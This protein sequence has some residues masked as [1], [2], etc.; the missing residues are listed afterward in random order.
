[1]K[2]AR[3]D[4]KSN[5]GPLSLEANALTHYTS[6][7]GVKT[8]NISNKYLCNLLCNTVPPNLY[9]GFINHHP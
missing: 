4:Q 7:A 2:D 8:F 1:M 6:T 5:L 9:D 3:P